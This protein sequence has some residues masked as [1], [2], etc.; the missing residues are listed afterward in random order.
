[1]RVS[2][3]SLLAALTA[4]GCIVLAALAGIVALAGGHGLS[5][6]V[7]QQLSGVLHHGPK[8]VVERPQRELGA[9]GDPDEFAQKFVFRN[10]GDSSLELTEGPTSCTCTTVDLPEGLIPPGGQA[11][12]NVHFNE[13]TKHDTL[14]AGPLTQSMTVF[15]NDLDSPCVV[16]R[17]SCTVALRAV[18]AP[19][20]FTLS[21]NPTDLSSEEKR[22]AQTLI[23]SHTWDHFDL[24]D[25]R[26]SLRGM[27]WRI[28]PAAKKELAA[29]QG[30]AATMSASP[31]RPTCRTGVS[32]RL[33]IFP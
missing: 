26:A 19:S 18:A 33:S 30:A 24:A 4:T 25:V 15:T 7:P 28:E 10:Q 22:S 9:I 11:V 29:V 27:Q 6:V 17:I 5:R 3:R 31:C 13:T 1:M 2:R 12:V 8:V 21:L 16:L 23:Y 14:K 32:P 20:N